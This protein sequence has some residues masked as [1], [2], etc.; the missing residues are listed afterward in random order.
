M[1]F[2]KNRVITKADWIIVGVSLF[3]LVLVTLG[4]FAAAS[5]VKGQI[6][7]VAAS[8]SKTHSELNEARAIAAKKDG[9]LKEIEKVREKISSF[10]DRLPT[11][12]EVPKLLRQFQRIAELSGVKYQ[13]ITAQ[14]IDEKELYVRLPYQVRVKGAY[15][16]IGEFLRSLEFGSRFIKV[17]N[18]DIGP[19][20]K[21]S[22]EA[23]FTISTYMFVSKE[24]ESESG[25]THS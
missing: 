7:T 6:K 1:D 19:E 10:E 2:F 13:L 20:D 22:S 16:E 4:Y 5:I 15:P 9:L 3:L 23:N 25:V 18:I 12:K 14:P 17:E 21:G 24:K 11:E 8:V